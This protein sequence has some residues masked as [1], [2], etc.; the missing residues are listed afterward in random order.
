MEKI[1]IGSLNRTKVEAVEEVFS[2]LVVEAINA[3][4][5][6]LA[7]PIG[8]EMTRLGAV[9]RARFVLHNSDG[10]YGIGFEGGV[11]FI[12][13]EL[14][15][16]NWGALIT[17]DRDEFTASGFYL[18]LPIE[19]RK[20]ILAGEELGNLIETY[21]EEKFSRTKG[22]AI[23]LLTNELIVRKDIYVHLATLLKGQLLHHQYRE[24]KRFE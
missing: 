23:G 3:P 16:C 6:V 15:L 21:T 24:N 17:R 20:P 1:I 8:N 14:Y 22:G 4:S 9:N 2:D 12:S 13:D 11:V 10:N 7:Q 5:K 19:F 18:P